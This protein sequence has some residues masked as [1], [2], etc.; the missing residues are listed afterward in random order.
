MILDRSFIDQSP[1][2]ELNDGSHLRTLE[3]LEDG[4]YFRHLVDGGYFQNNRQMI[5]K[6]WGL[7]IPCLFKVISSMT[8]LEKLNLLDWNL[9]LTQDFLQMLRS[10]PNLTELRLK[11]FDNKELEMD[12]ELKYKLRSC[13]QR[14]RIFELHWLT[15]SWPVLQEILT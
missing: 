7:T 4:K 8:H 9:K 15:I 3:R 6:S 12:E 14:L 13:F 11:L 5:L 2:T 10:C 1:N